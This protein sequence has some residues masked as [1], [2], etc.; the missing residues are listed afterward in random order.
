MPSTDDLEAAG[1]RAARGPVPHPPSIDT[2]VAEVDRRRGKRRRVAGGVAAA[3]VAVVV[4]PIGVAMIDDGPAEVVTLASDDVGE[5]LSG[6][7]ASLPSQNE[8]TTTSAP[9]TTLVS[10]TDTSPATTLL[11][12]SSEQG[13]F[14]GLS[15]ENF[16]LQLDLGDESFA[17]VVLHGEEALSRANDAAAAADET[18]E[19]DGQMVWLDEQ[20]DDLAASSLLEGESFVEVTGPRE[21][22]ERMLDLVTEYANGPLRFFDLDGFG[23]Q[24]DLPDGLLDGEGLF[25]EVFPFEEGDLPFLEGGALDDFRGE[26]KDFSDCMEITIDSSGAT[27]TVQIPD[28]ELPELD[29]LFDGLLKDF[30]FDLEGLFDDLEGAWAN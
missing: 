30:P 3:L 4:L 20:G 7:P 29:G 11:Q 27:T 23:E 25:D 14:A 15:D 16:D 10:T 24:F 28:C 8:P 1:R 12:E 5:S 19:I 13:P 22:L 21:Q 6:E 26:M 9:T 18:R 2:L 17:I